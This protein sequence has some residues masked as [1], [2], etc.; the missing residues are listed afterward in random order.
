MVGQ[1][2]ERRPIVV[3][4]QERSMTEATGEWEIPS[5]NQ[6][7]GIDRKVD[8]PAIEAG[9]YVVELVSVSDPELI[10]D[11]QRNP[12]GNKKQFTADW[13][14]VSDPSGDT[15]HQ[16]YKVR[17]WYTLSMHEKSN[18]Y[19]VVKAMFGSDLDPKVPITPDQI[20]HKRIQAYVAQPDLTEEEI[21]EGR[22]PWPRLSNP[23]PLPKKYTAIPLETEEVPF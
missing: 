11:P 2:C 23:M 21:R 20:L 17:A 18:L 8:I 12:N 6:S 1:W 9:L 4:T 13:V 10:E 16:G 19:K 15:T 5:F 7:N 3:A 14:V 22:L